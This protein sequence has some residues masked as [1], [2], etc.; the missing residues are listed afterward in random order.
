[1]SLKPK[2]RTE[3][4]RKKSTDFTSKVKENVKDFGQGIR[5]DSV[6]LKNAY[7]A[8][9]AAKAREKQMKSGKE[10]TGAAAAKALPQYLCSRCREFPAEECVT[11]TETGRLWKSSLKRILWHKNGCQLCSLL[12]KV[13]CEPRNDPFKHPQIAE[14]LHKDFKG[15]T[16]A[17]WI[18]MEKSWDTILNNVDAGMSKWP[19]GTG[20]ILASEKDI[21]DGGTHYAGKFGRAAWNIGVQG[22]SGYAFLHENNAFAS[23][24]TKAL[25]LQTTLPCF[26]E[27]LRNPLAPGLLDAKLWGFG[28]GP[29]AQIAELCSFRLRVQVDNPT[30]TSS[31]TQ[32]PFHYGRILNPGT[33]DLSI[34]KFWLSNCEETHGDAC[35]EQGWFFALQKP[36]FIRVIDVWDFCL[37]EVTDPEVSLPRYVALSYVW[38][39]ARQFMLQTYNKKELMEKNGLLQ[40]F[41]YDFPRTIRDAMVATYGMG[42]RYIWVDCL[43]IEQD[44]EEDKIRQINNMDSIYGHAVLTMV[45]ADAH[46]ARVGLTGVLEGSRNVVQTTAELKTGVHLM[47]P[48]PEPRGLEASPWNTRAW[49]FQERLLARRLAIFIGGRL[50]WRCRRVVAFEDMTALEMGE[51]LEEFPSLSI[52]PQHLGIKTPRKGYID[53]S[54]EKLRDGRTQIVRSE[55]FKE[56]VILVENYTQRMLTHSSDVLKALAGLLNIF[57]LCF[58]CPVNQ[59]LPEI[60]LDAAIL[61]RPCQRLIRRQDPSIPSWTWAGW[62]GKVSYE[63]AFL[64]QVENDR[65]LKRIPNQTGQE[66]FRPLLRWHTWRNEKMMMINRNGIGIPLSLE[67][68]RSLPDEWDKA[69]PGFTANDRDTQSDA[70]HD[71]EDQIESLLLDSSKSLEKGLEIHPHHMPQDQS[72]HLNERQLIFRTSC[73]SAFYFGA[74]LNA[75]ELYAPVPMRYTLLDAKSS[76]EIGN[77]ILDSSTPAQVEPSRHQLVV[78]SEAQYMDLQQE[79]DEDESSANFALYNVML[80]ER[81]QETGVCR[82]LGLGRVYKL[83]WGALQPV[84]DLRVVVLE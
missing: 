84:P 60:L 12:I 80:V 72:Y 29:R 50:V 13:L 64:T 35:N 67:E 15:K 37:V 22:I 11:S 20:E 52:K 61:W 56:Y 78:L 40:H 28:R 32:L 73:T 19:F 66:G 43:C 76:A 53:G 59:G 33:I 39:Q 26:V 81:N 55:T 17:E 45:A 36:N 30:V 42:E 41:H 77:I 71:I 68:G 69:P 75:S 9:R 7:S 25:K 27:V 83:L 54:I 47:S 79:V 51:D 31:E 10:P 24:N 2:S 48:L 34:G 21:A 58:K 8:D 46:D 74:L 1:M 63:E 70:L 44:N 4:L 3:L 62:H 14:H 49:T 6:D 5:N 65:W 16:M 18:K 57:E 82:R 38:G 23:N